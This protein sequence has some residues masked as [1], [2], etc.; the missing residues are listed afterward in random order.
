VI[1]AALL[2]STYKRG[3]DFVHVPTTLLSQ[4]DASVGG[5][6]GI[7][8]DSIKNIVGTFAQ[9]KA[10]FMEHSFIKYAAPAP[11]RYPAWPRC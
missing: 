5:K 2:A 10:V 4:V 11:E 1:W 6:T 8:I 9:P 7:D 3:I